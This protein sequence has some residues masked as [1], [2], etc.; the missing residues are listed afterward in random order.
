MNMLVR[1]AAVLTAA[2]SL[3]TLGAVAQQERGVLQGWLQLFDAFERG[4]DGT[5]AVVY[6]LQDASYHVLVTALEPQESYFVYLVE[7][8]PP[9]LVGL[10]MD[11]SAWGGTETGA[12]AGD[13]DKFLFLGEIVTNTR[14]D[15]LISV[16][17]G[18]DSAAMVR[19][20]NMVF[21][22]EERRTPGQ[23][24]TTALLGCNGEFYG[25]G[26]G[27]EYDVETQE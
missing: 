10:A 2:L 13:D 16:S 7:H 23:P 3:V 1:R 22:F 6:D 9:E 8:R 17:L 14:G 12:A 4:I 25:V 15:G 5:G 19:R 26:P 20:F 24:V 27:M 21:V 11:W 18:A